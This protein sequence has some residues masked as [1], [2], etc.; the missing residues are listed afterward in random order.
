MFRIQTHQLAV[1]ICNSLQHAQGFFR[2]EDAFPV[3]SFIEV[4]IS[5]LNF[6]FETAFGELGLFI[7]AATTLEGTHMCRASEFLQSFESALCV[8]DLKQG[9]THFVTLLLVLIFQYE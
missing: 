3:S 1:I 5:E 8:S 6:Y 2:P 4:V 9:F 7:A